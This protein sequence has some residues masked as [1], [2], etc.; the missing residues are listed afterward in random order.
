MCCKID[1]RSVE[2]EEHEILNELSISAQSFLLLGMGLQETF[3]DCLSNASA[4]EDM[5][6][7]HERRERTGSFLGSSGP[8]DSNESFENQ[9][10]QIENGD[11]SE[12][13]GEDVGEYEEANEEDEDE[14][15]NEVES[16][17]SDDEA[18]V[19]D[20]DYTVIGADLLQNTFESSEIRSPLHT[21]SDL[22]ENRDLSNSLNEIDAPSSVDNVQYIGRVLLRS[23]E[24]ENESTDRGNASFQFARC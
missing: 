8:S 3:H 10:L 18:I 7:A 16:G 12:H 22:D 5:Q 23:L 19:I 1:N 4:N 21:D 14:D 6:F 20:D 9:T 15:L 24:G 17:N 13:E 11:E 2:P